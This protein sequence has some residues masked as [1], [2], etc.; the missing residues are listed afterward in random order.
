MNAFNAKIGWLVVAAMLVLSACEERDQVPPQNVI[1]ILS[2]D[3]RYD[4][5][6]FTG[7]VPFLETPNM[8][9][10]A[11]EGTYMEYAFVTTA[12]CSPSRAS[13][14]TGQYTHRHGVIDN[15]SM[16]PDGTRFFPEFL[17][18][19][20]YQTGFVGKWHMGE[21]KNDPRPGFDYWASFTGQGK[22]WNSVFNVNGQEETPADSTYVTDA[23]TN[24]ALDFL[25]NR[26]LSKPFFLYVS[27][28]AVHAEFMADPD[29]LGRYAAEAPAYPPS[30]FPPGHER[31][32]PAAADYNYAD[33]PE[34]VKRQRYSW[35]GVDYMYHGQIG[36]DD[37]YRAYCETLLGVDESIGEIIRYVEDNGLADQTTFI[38][39]GDNGFSFGEHGLI[40]KRHAYEESM[41]VPL[42]VMTPG[43]S[44]PGM[45][46]RQPVQNIDIGP[47]ILDIAG[48]KPHPQFDGKSFLPLLEGQTGDFD[49]DTIYYEY[50]W[51]RPF[52]QTPTVHAVRT[53]KY[54][55]IRYHGIWDVNELYDIE[56]DPWE[57]NNLIRNPEYKEVASGLRTALFEW[58]QRT[59]GEQMLLRPDGRGGRFDYGYEGTY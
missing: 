23:V 17:Q 47:T 16:V 24:Y 25:E 14:L 31:A 41:R 36:F 2:D 28:K 11:R 44:S 58:L 33:V 22:Y 43:N 12:L 49:R 19:Q 56:K 8:D 18:Q 38:Y 6:G 1:F 54:K 5:M 30:M 7:K 42:L 59:Q 13:I 55:Y 50:F 32:S 9:R 34:W 20:G 4:F 10:M 48:L 52:P 15:Q 26:D 35:H 27:H 21:H 37:F 57:M 46:I 39:M 40:D 53:P 51:E 3:H 45:T 29:H